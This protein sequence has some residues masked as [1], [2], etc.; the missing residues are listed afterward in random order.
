[1]GHQHRH[2]R[3]HSWALV[4]WC[5]PLPPTAP[6]RMAPERVGMLL[7]SAV[8]SQVPGLGVPG[9]RGELELRMGVWKS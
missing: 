7:S 8:S 1:M 4:L 3:V 9:G 6:C 5:L 2:K